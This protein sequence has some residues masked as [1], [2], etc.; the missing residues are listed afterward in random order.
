MFSKRV[1]IISFS[2]VKCREFP[3]DIHDIF[4]KF[5]RDLD[6]HKVLQ[7]CIKTIVF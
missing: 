5:I 6:T 4:Y 3:Q 7:I 1:L 2:R